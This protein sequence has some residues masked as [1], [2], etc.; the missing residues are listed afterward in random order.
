MRVLIL[1]L[2]S[3][4]DTIFPNCLH[5][6][7]GRLVC[8]MFLDSFGVDNVKLLTVHYSTILTCKSNYI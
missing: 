8:N 7:V 1:W 3:F 5:E 4:A 2:Y 6:Y